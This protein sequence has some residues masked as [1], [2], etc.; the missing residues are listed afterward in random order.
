[1]VKKINNKLVYNCILNG[2]ESL[3]LNSLQLYFLLV[4]EVLL[5]F[6]FPIQELRFLYQ[7][8]ALAFVLP[9]YSSW[10]LAVLS[11]YREHKVLLFFCYQSI[12]NISC[13]VFHV[14]FTSLF[15][16]LYQQ[17]IRDIKFFC[18]F[19]YQHLLRVKYKIVLHDCVHQTWILSC[20]VFHVM[21]QN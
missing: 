6:G 9:L 2:Q 1:M 4:G 3:N 20:C 17:S 7:R 21:F 5:F 8:E 12:G 11:K 15:F 10:L 14:C 16:L 18:Y 19:L 13:C